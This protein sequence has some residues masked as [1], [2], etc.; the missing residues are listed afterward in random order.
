MEAERAPLKT[1]ILYMGP[2]MGFHV[3]LGEGRLVVLHTYLGLQRAIS[4]L[5]GR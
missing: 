5:L 3:N 1:T 4:G 2:S